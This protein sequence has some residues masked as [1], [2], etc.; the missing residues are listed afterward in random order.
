MKMGSLGAI[1]GIDHEEQI[2]KKREL[3]KE[4]ENKKKTKIKRRVNEKMKNPEYID[5][6]EDPSIGSPFNVPDEFLDNEEEE[7]KGVNLRKILRIVRYMEMA[8]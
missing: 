3:E 5:E 2:K 1:A 4:L 8:G 7:D 6:P